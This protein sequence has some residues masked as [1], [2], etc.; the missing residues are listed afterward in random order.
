MEKGGESMLKEID[1]MELI[2][3]QVNLVD[4]SLSYLEINMFRQL[5]RHVYGI[6]Y[7]LLSKVLWI[8]NSLEHVNFPLLNNICLPCTFCRKSGVNCRKWRKH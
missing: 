1:T 5:L 6:I 8:F 3:E 4:M 2:S 7:I